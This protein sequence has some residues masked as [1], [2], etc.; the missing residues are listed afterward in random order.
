VSGR[1]LHK[2]GRPAVVA[3]GFAEVRLSEGE[4]WLTR[5]SDGRFDRLLPRRGTYHVQVGPPGEPIVTRAITAGEEPVWL[6]IALDALAPPVRGRPV[7][8]TSIDDRCAP[9]GECPE[10]GRARFCFIEG[11]CVPVGTRQAGAAGLCDPDREPLAW[12]APAS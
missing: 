2:D 7:V 8:A 10:P 11:R 12:S 3:V 9:E 4:R 6:D 5:C 1:V